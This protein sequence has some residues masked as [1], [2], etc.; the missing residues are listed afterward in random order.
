MVEFATAHFKQDNL[1]FQVTD[2]EHLTHASKFD[3]AVG[4][5]CIP[6]VT[7]K[8]LALSSCLIFEHALQHQ[9]YKRIQKLLHIFLH[10]FTTETVCSMHLRSYF[11]IG[12]HHPH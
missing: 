10:R 3:A 5:F 9:S 7:N 6:W 11:P 2:V 1:N 4:F 8:A 12:F